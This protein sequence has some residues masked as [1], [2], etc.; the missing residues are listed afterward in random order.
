MPQPDIKEVVRG[1][2]AEIARS[3]RARGSSCCYDGE[4][5]SCVNS[6]NLYA[7]DQT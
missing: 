3:V 5:G 2:Y 6:A 7:D 4:A 1:R